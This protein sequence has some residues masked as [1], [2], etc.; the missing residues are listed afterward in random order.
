MLPMTRLARSIGTAVI[1]VPIAAF[2]VWA[3]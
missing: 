1:A 3:L 2:I